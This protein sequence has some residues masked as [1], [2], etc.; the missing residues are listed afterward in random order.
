MS[1]QCPIQFYLKARTLDKW[2]PLSR[3]ERI[4]FLSSTSFP[5]AAGT[6]CQWPVMT[7]IFIVA[8]VHPLLSF[9]QVNLREYQYFSSAPYVH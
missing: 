7:P 3:L 5:Q 2:F 4:I 9:S 8:I 1:I 6:P